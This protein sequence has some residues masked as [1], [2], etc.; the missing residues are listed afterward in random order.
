MGSYT[1]GL[2]IGRAFALANAS[3]VPEDDAVCELLNLAQSEPEALLVARGRFRSFLDAH[4]DSI[5]DRR[6][7]RLIEA[8][9]G[10]CAA[11]EGELVGAAG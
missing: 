3:T 8:A 4:P 1:A 11:T 2:L 5:E 7:L 10:R 9:A 6:A